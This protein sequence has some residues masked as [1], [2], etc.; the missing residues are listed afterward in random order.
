MRCC[1]LVLEHLRIEIR[2]TVLG[3]GFFVAVDKG[4]VIAT[5]EEHDAGTVG[6]VVI[7]VGDNIVEELVDGCRIALGGRSLLGANG[8]QIHKK[9]VVF[10]SCII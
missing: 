5:C 1:W 2:E 6:D 8:T 10:I 7:W 4:S 3:C 9:L